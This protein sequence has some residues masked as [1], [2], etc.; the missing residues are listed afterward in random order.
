MLDFL[1]LTIRA[2]TK[3]IA[4]I[5]SSG[6]TAAVTSTPPSDNSRVPRAWSHLRSPQPRHGR[7]LGRTV[8]G[9]RPAQIVGS[10]FSRRCFATA[11]PSRGNDGA[12]LSA[13]AAQRPVTLR[14]PCSARPSKGERPGAAY[15]S[16]LALFAPPATTASRCAGM[17]SEPVDRFTSSQDDGVAVV[18]LRPARCW[19]PARSR[20]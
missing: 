7:C 19:S 14:W 6:N 10:W 1:S 16:R 13:G 8:S 18:A 17:T 15:P 3:R 11:K 9:R 12:A 20:R 4:I 2:G 5:I